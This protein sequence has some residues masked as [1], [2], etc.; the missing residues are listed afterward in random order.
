MKKSQGGFLRPGYTLE[1]RLTQTFSVS[2][3]KKPVEKFINFFKFE[4]SSAI[5]YK[6]FQQKVSRKLLKKAP[7]LGL[8]LNKTFLN[9]AQEEPSRGDSYQSHTTGKQ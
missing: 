5:K 2:V 8:E 7:I 6:F 1:L 4:K 3:H 9:Y